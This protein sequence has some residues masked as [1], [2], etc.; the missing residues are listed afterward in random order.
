[1]KKFLYKD[2]YYDEDVGKEKKI[3]YHQLSYDGGVFV[4]FYIANELLFEV[5]IEN[6][7]IPYNKASYVCKNKETND[8]FSVT[9][10]QN[11]LKRPPN[12]IVKKKEPS[13]ADKNFDERRLKKS[14]ALK[15]INVKFLKQTGE[16]KK[17]ADKFFSNGYSFKK[18]F[19][20]FYDEKDL[21]TNKKTIYKLCFYFVFVV[22]AGWLS[23]SESNPVICIIYG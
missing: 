3:E 10:A 4:S 22:K 15:K 16:N 9:K 2:K 14:V 6:L 17:K 1:M 11:S 19:N 8:E 21:K 7:E 13:N 5:E 23:S 12:F 20:Q 18:N